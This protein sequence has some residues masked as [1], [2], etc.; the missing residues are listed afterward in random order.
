MGEIGGLWPEPETVPGHPEL[1]DRAWHLVLNRDVPSVAAL[2]P[3]IS[4]FI[5]HGHAAIAQ[6]ERRSVVVRIRTVHPSVGDPLQ[7]MI[8][9]TRVLR[10]IDAAW[11]IQE[12]QGLP[13]RES[14]LLR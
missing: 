2:A 4:E 5:E 13:G 8:L 7:A 14:L 10:A 1:V 6:A 3:A 12:L 9:T 11:G